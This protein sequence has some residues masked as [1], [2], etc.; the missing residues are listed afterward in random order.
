MRTIRERPSL[1]G[2]HFRC[3]ITKQYTLAGA[4]GVPPI[5]AYS[6]GSSLSSDCSSA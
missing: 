2:H 1:E 3:K 4:I 5:G 6:A